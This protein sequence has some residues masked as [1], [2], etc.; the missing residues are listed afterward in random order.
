[1]ARRVK[2]LLEENDISVFSSSHVKV[3]FHRASMER[4]RKINTKKPNCR[5][6]INEINKLQLINSKPNR[7]LEVIKAKVI[8]FY[9]NY[10]K[11]FY[12]IYHS[13]IHNLHAA[14]T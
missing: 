8:N 13:V 1:M 11:I 3:E 10:F 4:I 6:N 7:L 5:T 14:S 2:Q 9:I 12:I